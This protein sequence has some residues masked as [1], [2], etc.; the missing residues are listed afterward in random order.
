[1]AVKTEYQT[2]DEQEIVSR[3]I[4]GEKELFEILI[5]RI[6]PYL[7]KIG[8]SYGYEYHDVE[9]LMQEAFISSYI[10]LKE[11]ENRS[12]FKTWISRIMLNLCY[13]KQQKLSFKNEMNGI[14]IDNETLLPL[15]A[16][17]TSSDINKIIMNK[18]IRQ[19]V[20]T[21]LLKLPLDYR[22]V[23]SLRELNE[24]DTAETA[25]LL[26]ISEGNVKARLSR[27]KVMLRKT[28]EKMYSGEEIFEFNLIYCDAIVN[29]VMNAIDKI[30]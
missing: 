15:Y 3:I 21:A 13:H 30:V 4:K 22:M 8:R 23:F 11:F 7:Y 24:M 2:L 12:S 17:R 6:N 28:V 26:N 27:A 9:D 14:D 25:E 10:H 18:E 20:E 29:N 5:R 16:N 1:M 19:I